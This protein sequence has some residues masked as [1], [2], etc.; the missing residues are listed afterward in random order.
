MTS[1]QTVTPS[2]IRT[3]RRYLEEF[4]D[5]RARLFMRTIEE[6]LDQLTDKDIKEL[7]SSKCYAAFKTTEF[8][9]D[10]TS[11]SGKQEQMILAAFELCW[12]MRIYSIKKMEEI[13]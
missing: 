10:I 4:V 3:E 2:E 1:R 13:Q 12:Q 11:P 5:S 6:Y 9:S 8:Y 7:T